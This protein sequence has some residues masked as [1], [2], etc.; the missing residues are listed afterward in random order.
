[1]TA[2]ATDLGAAWDAVHDATLVGWLDGRATMPRCGLAQPSPTVIA[3][4]LEAA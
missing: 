3:D 1:M 2:D 4:D